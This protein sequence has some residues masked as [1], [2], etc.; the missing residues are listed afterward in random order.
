LLSHFLA[1]FLRQ[2]F[3]SNRQTYGCL[4]NGRA[5]VKIKQ[6]QTLALQ[7]RNARRVKR[8][9]GPKN[10]LGLIKRQFGVERFGRDAQKPGSLRLIAAAGAKRAFDGLAFSFR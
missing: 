8:Y 5:T 4:S 1:P 3:I 7:L 9:C 6:F 10:L 2:L